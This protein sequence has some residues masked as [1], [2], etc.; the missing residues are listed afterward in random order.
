MCEP[1]EHASLGIASLFNRAEVDVAPPSP[2]P[3]APTRRAPPH[4]Q[5]KPDAKAP[6]LPSG[7]GL[8]PCAVDTPPCRSNPFALRA[9]GPRKAKATDSAGVAPRPSKKRGRGK[10]PPAPTM[11]HMYVC[12]CVC[13]CV[14]ACVDG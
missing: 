14:Y 4:L 7:G 10:K 11:L 5:H 3:P 2:P 8:T 6:T 9:A 13:V 1:V 12:V